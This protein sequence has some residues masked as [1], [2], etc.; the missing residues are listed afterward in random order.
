MGQQK[1][2]DLPVANEKDLDDDNIVFE[3]LDN[4]PKEPA[5][6]KKVKFGALK[7]RTDSGSNSQNI[8]L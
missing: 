2:I 6:P 7:R 4:V 5:K 3:D 8:N 1:S